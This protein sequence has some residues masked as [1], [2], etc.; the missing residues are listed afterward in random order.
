LARIL[1]LDWDQRLVHIVAAQTGRGGARIE[2]A[3]QFE[4][5]LDL[6]P[7]NASQAGQ[8]LR[9]RLKEFGFVGGPVLICTGRERVILKEVRHPSVPPSEEP[10]LVRFQ[11]SKDLTE[12]ADEVVIDYQP[13]GA[14]PQG[15]RQAMAVIVRK[16]MLTAYQTVCRVAGLRLAAI[17]PRAFGAAGA[18][19]RATGVMLTPGPVTPDA[20]LGVLTLGE[21]WAELCILRGRTVLLARSLTIGA[22]LPGEIKRSLTV[23]AGTHGDNMPQALYVAGNGEHGPLRE[24]LHQ[25]IG[26]P[27][28]ALDPF[29]SEEKVDVRAKTRGGFTG[30]V[31]LLHLW[32]KSERLPINLAKPKEPKPES[33]PRKRK[34]IL[35]AC[36]A[37]AGFI[38]LLIYGQFVLS[39]Q[40]EDLALQRQAKNNRQAA[41]AKLEEDSTDVAELKNWDATTVPWLEELYDVSRRMDFRENFHLNSLTMGPAPKRGDAGKKGPAT[42]P[43]Y[44]GQITMAGV[45][46]LKQ[47]YLISNL[48]SRL[49]VDKHLNAV[50][51]PAT[52]T[53]EE[54]EFRFTVSVL[55]QPPSAYEGRLEVP[56]VPSASSAPKKKKGGR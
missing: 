43:S 6:T 40:A 50:R 23:Y 39:A 49:G 4:E 9:E 15:D 8:R 5:D 51:G 47:D 14:G 41:L 19:E 30:A 1:A 24:R 55:K 31:G 7:Q 45:A 52:K 48:A 3:V 36:A 27:V 42:G 10:A 53:G 25:A 56:S 28:H 13:L 17:A 22:T 38:L 32:S 29:A 18:V 44:A 34:K 11:A 26:L 37:A 16:D 54:E 2:K 12:T 21:R 46:P 35:I 33:D 20:V